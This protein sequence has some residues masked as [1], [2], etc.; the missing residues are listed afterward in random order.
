MS[1]SRVAL[2]AA[3]R[4][5][6]P[7]VPLRSIT[8]F[9]CSRNPQLWGSKRTSNYVRDCTLLALYKDLYSVGYS[10]LFNRIKRW[11]PTSTQ[12]LQHNTKIICTLLAKWGKKRITLGTLRDWQRAAANQPFPKRG[13]PYRPLA[14]LNTSGWLGKQVAHTQA[15]S[16]LSSATALVTATP[17]CLTLEAE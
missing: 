4:R 7:Q 3:V 12:S 10:A 15:R 2:E 11:M 14:G 13:A 5:K 16:G 17:F 8:T 1:L 6:I 9:V